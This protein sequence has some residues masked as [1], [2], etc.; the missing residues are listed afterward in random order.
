[1]KDAVR[2]I[3]AGAIALLVGLMFILGADSIDIVYSI[4]NRT[5]SVIGGSA[6][7]TLGAVKL[8]KSIMTTL[9]IIFIAAG[10]A[11]VLWGLFQ[12]IGGTPMGKYWE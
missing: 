11:L 9:G 12:V 6:T 4:V 5:V 10:G 1:M 8:V 2:K 3:V 7:F